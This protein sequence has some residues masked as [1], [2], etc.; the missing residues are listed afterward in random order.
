SNLRHQ[1]TFRNDRIVTETLDLPID[2]TKEDQAGILTQL[3]FQIIAEGNVPPHIIFI[4]L[5]V[6]VP[7]LNPQTFS[8]MREAC[9]A[10]MDLFRQNNFLSLPKTG[11]VLADTIDVVVRHGPA[12][13]SLLCVGS[14]G[15]LETWQV[16][17]L[18]LFPLF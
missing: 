1:T 5:L 13:R 18:G 10:A 6:I 4:L 9:I 14:T 2:F 12:L 3:V 8:V 17:F 11:D 7:R 15:L 16:L